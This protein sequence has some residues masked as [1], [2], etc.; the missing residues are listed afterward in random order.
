[1][2]GQPKLEAFFLSLIPYSK[3]Y[4]EESYSIPPQKKTILPKVNISK[5]TTN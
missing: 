4:N 5:I 1:M 3:K 2:A